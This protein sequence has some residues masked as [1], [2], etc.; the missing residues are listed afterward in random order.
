MPNFSKK[1]SSKN[2]DEVMQKEFL[3]VSK[4]TTFNE[5]V[6]ILSNCALSAPL[7]K[8][9]LPLVESHQ[10]KTFL[11]VAPCSEILKILHKKDRKFEKLTMKILKTEYEKMRNDGDEFSEEKFVKNIKKHFLQFEKNHFQEGEAYGT[12][13]STGEYHPSPSSFDRSNVDFNN[14]KV[15][16]PF[17]VSQYSS[18]RDLFPLP[19]QNNEEDSFSLFPT[20][21]PHKKKK[22]KPRFSPKKVY[23]SDE[24]VSLIL[25]SSSSS[26]SHQ[27][28]H[29]APPQSHQPQKHHFLSPISLKKAPSPRQFNQPLSNPTTTTSE[30]DTNKHSPVSQEEEQSSPQQR[31]ILPP[32]LSSPQLNQQQQIDPQ[33]AQETNIIL[34]D[35]N[36]QL[37]R[38]VRS[39]KKIKVPPPPS[40]PNPPSLFFSLFS[41]LILKKKKKRG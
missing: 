39:V 23:N 29:I 30:L 21:S 31:I 37:P 1:T 10:T 22:R 2:V 17:S 41:F 6:S 9:A 8:S 18:Y 26:V 19:Q 36:P 14:K 5:L 4:S 38:N 15:M 20:S 7:S 13:I 11:G 40:N 27:H 35:E 25:S 33:T 16:N 34:D 28:H 3:F 12:Y 24:N 32:K